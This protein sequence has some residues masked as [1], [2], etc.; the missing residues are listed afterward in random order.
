MTHPL[1]VA[2]ISIRDVQS[3]FRYLAGRAAK[4]ANAKFARIILRAMRVIIAHPPLRRVALRI[5]ARVPRLEA[6]LLRLLLRDIGADGGSQDLVAS[7][8]ADLSPRA[9]EIYVRLKTAV[10]RRHET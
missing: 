3:N 7:D 8:I 6:K 10:D 2:L 1:H 5:V 9:I 4:S